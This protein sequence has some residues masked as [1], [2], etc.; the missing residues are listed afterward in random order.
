MK[1]VVAV[2]TLPF[3]C[4][5]S[6]ETRDRFTKTRAGENRNEAEKV[7]APFISLP[8]GIRNDGNLAAWNVWCEK[9]H[10][11]RHLY[12]KVIFLPRQARDKHREISKKSGVFR[13]AQDLSDGPGLTLHTPAAKGRHQDLSAA[14]H[15]HT[16]PYVGLLRCGLLLQSAC[17]CSAQHLCISLRI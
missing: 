5:L 12:I 2:E 4:L 15:G 13:R 9:R 6:Y 10:F 11:L 7:V 3:F 17:T 14:S 1:P 8:A 16:G